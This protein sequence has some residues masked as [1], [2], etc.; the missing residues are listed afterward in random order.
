MHHHP[1]QPSGPLRRRLS[2]RGFLRAAG[3][4]AAGVALGGAVAC[5]PAQD[6]PGQGPSGPL[7][8][9]FVPIACAAPLILADSEGL[10]AAHGVDVRLKKYAGW[11][12]LWT[13]YATGE[14]DVAH[15]LSPMPAAIDSGATNA[16]RPTELSFTQNT[17]GQALTLAAEHHPEVRG[18]EDM[19][20]MILGI[21]F[22][23]SVHA[24]LLRDFLAA[25]GVD[26]VA[27]V[28]LR[29]LRPADMV[30][31]LEVGGIDGF[32][33]PEPF[34]QRALQSGA[35]R[36]FTL[37]KDL[38]DK[39][40]CCS[41]AMA[42]DWRAAHPETADGLIAAL[43]EAAVLA[44]DP[45]RTGHVSPVLAQE[46]YLNQPTG[47]ITP[48]LE[49]SYLTWGGEQV[50]DPEL[51]SFG[52]PTDVTA[53]TWMT[54]QMARWDLGGDAL[55]MD[56]DVLIRASRSVLPA[57]V[58]RAGDPVMINGHRFDPARPTAGYARS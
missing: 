12:D 38:W 36:I 23:Y 50:V 20:G 14:L 5:S 35:G 15:M 28:E 51:M 25:G 22:E 9:G 46:K 21:P 6:S 44:D 39:H 45:A 54:T 57:D 42:K 34:N 40:P 8:I 13:A 27:D 2:R 31:Q 37:T 56:D 29:L 11:A 19:R 47:L 1:R 24:L 32:I 43:G 7:T 4:T 55:R 3:L 33:G 48:E 16:T 26:P 18:A 41:V 49:G 53:I 52:D 58:P 17:N 30:A 10:F